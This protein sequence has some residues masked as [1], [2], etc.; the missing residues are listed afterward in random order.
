M[1]PRD[2]KLLLVLLVGALLLFGIPIWIAVLGARL[3]I[4]HGVA[5]GRI[6]N[7]R[8]V[9]E[10]GEHGGARALLPGESTSLALSYAQTGKP[11]K[12]RFEL[13]VDGSRV[14]LTSRRTFVVAP[15]EEQRLVIDPGL[16]VTHPITSPAPAASNSES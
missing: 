16:A 12:L 11:F 3:E 6:E 13:V 8:W 9:D 7:L 2:L 15:R 4:E 10:E 14:V 1:K 5:G